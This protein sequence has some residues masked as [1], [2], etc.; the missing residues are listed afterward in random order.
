MKDRIEIFNV[1]QFPD[2]KNPEDYIKRG[3]ESI[4]RNPLIANTL[5]LCKDIEKWGS[6][7]KRITEECVLVGIKVRFEET[8]AG[9]KVIFPRPEQKLELGVKLGVRLGVNEQ[10]IV[11]LIVKNNHL[12]HEELSIQL[13][14]SAVSVYKNIRKLKE[15]GILKRIG[16]DKSGYWEVLK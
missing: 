7:L 1:G 12:T 2:G 15:K 8:S 10:K 3:E 13:K 5:F 6:G 11:G 4:P 9:F 16:S 14:I